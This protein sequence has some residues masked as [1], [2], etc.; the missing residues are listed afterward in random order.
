[1]K[2]RE[3][4]PHRSAHGWRAARASRPILAALALLVAAGCQ[5]TETATTHYP[6]GELWTVR[7][8]RAGVPLDPWI[9]LWPNDSTR[10]E[11]FY[12]EGR[13]EGRWRT[14]SPRGEL[15]LERFYADDELHGTWK[16][17]VPGGQLVEEGRFERGR[18]VGTWRRFAADGT[19]L[20]SEDFGG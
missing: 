8:F 15:L 19:L 17:F 5:P 6:T 3:P 12:V 10:H 20:S 13:R 11:Q 1:V 2:P 14:A 7:R 9:V 18:R 16:R 4:L